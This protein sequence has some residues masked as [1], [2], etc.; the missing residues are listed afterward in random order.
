MIKEHSVLGSDAL[1]SSNSLK[2]IAKYVL[3]YH[4]RWDGGGY[5][6]GLKE[7]ETPLESQI[8]SAADA[9][10]AR[11]SKRT[12]R[13]PLS[14]NQALAEVKEN[15]GTQFSPVVADALLRVLED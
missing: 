10:D 13:E 11:S 8:L 14:Y 1:K 6:V 2:H 12:Y 4:E 3:H 7:E 15:K 9:W 5:P